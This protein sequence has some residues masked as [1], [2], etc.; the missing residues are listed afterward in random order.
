MFSSLEVLFNR[1]AGFGRSSIFALKQSRT[2]SRSLIKY[3]GLHNVCLRN[4]VFSTAVV[5]DF[6]EPGDMHS[7]AGL[8]ICISSYKPFQLDRARR[9]YIILPN[10]THC[11]L[12]Q[13]RNLGSRSWTEL[14]RLR[15]MI[16]TFAR[17][18]RLAYHYFAQFTPSR[19]CSYTKSLSATPP[20]K[21]RSFQAYRWQTI[22]S[23]IT[24]ELSWILWAIW[25]CDLLLFLIS[26][27]LDSPR[28]IHHLMAL[29]SFFLNVFEAFCRARTPS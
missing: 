7:G 13:N 6:C 3:S 14:R 19:R 2:S 25:P 4:N 1:V 26:R 12:P 28:G 23:T 8:S 15:C 9:P 24:K 27:R 22:V 21:T 18:S 11:G 5:L 20:R 16:T 10:P 17:Y 29:V